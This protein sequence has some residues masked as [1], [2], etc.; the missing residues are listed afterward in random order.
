MSKA[1]AKLIFPIRP[2]VAGL[3]VMVSAS[4]IFGAASIFLRGPDADYIPQMALI[5][6]ASSSGGELFVQAREV[7]ISEW[8][9]CHASGDCT[10]Q[11]RPPVGHTGADYPATGLNWVDVNEYLTWIN[12]KSRHTFRLPTSGEWTAMAASVMPK[13]PDP[14][15][16][17]PELTWA[18]TY[19]TEGL[20]SRKLEPSGS[21]SQTVE[22]IGDLDGNVWEWT[23]DCYAGASEGQR[24]DPNVCPAFFVGGEHEAVIPFLVRDPARGGCAVGAPPPHLGMRLVSDSPLP[25]H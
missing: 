15:F 21:Y 23:R 17:D 22:G 14:I 19:L 11:L 25:A 18:S 10:L 4:V 13:K 9:R 5:P 2:I 24:L 20:V 3:S 12:K 7:T 1:P 8:N 16:T 6:V